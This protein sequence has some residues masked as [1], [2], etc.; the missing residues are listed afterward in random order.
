M[1]KEKACP[2]FEQSLIHGFAPPALE[3]AS[4]CFA[5]TE[6]ARYQT[7]LQAVEGSM[8]L[9]EN[10]CPQPVVRL[11]CRREGPVGLAM[12]WGST[13]VVVKAF[14]KQGALSAMVTLDESFHRQSCVITVGNRSNAGRRLMY[15]DARKKC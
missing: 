11:E 3:I 7:A 6:T 1:I 9:Y 8:P 5:F 15:S 10:Y 12:Q 4:W 14:G 13:D 2:L